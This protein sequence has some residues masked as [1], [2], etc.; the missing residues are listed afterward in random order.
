VD[1]VERIP[2]SGRRLLPCRLEPVRSLT[3]VAVQRQPG[4]GIRR[5]RGSNE[6]KHLGHG[7]RRA[8]LALALDGGDRSGD[9][10]DGWRG[11]RPAHGRTARPPAGRPTTTRV[12]ASSSCPSREDAAACMVGRS[13][14][15][16]SDITTDF[17][18]PVFLR[19]YARS[20]A[21]FGGRELGAGALLLERRRLHRAS[22]ASWRQV[23][24]CVT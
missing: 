7:S 13:T 5:P 21:A 3:S 16:H 8:P 4:W 17:E 1:T 18:T 14:N 19:C 22:R 9:R 24:P 15:R 2:E 10:S 11:R 20:A 12:D 6:A 23:S